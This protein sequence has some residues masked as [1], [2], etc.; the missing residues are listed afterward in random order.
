[1]WQTSQE[2]KILISR[3][4][5]MPCPQMIAPLMHLEYLNLSRALFCG[6]VTFLLNLALKDKFFLS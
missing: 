4:H 3:C 6:L 1:M 2:A 5:A